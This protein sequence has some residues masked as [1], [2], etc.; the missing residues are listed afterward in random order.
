MEENEKK[1]TEETMSPQEA[2]QQNVESPETEESEALVSEKAEES[3]KDPV[4]A[5]E[6]AQVAATEST[7]VEDTVKESEPTVEPTKQEVKQLLMEKLDFEKATKEELFDAL[8]EVASNDEIRQ[9]D[10]AIKELKPV[11]EKLYQQEKSDALAAFMEQEGNEEG[12][13]KFLGDEIDRQFFYLSDNLRTKRKKY[14]ASLEKEKDANLQLKNDLLD[15]LREIVDGEETTNSINKVK[16]FQSQWKKIGPVPGQHNGALWAN[17]NALLDRFYDNRSIYFELKELDRKKNYEAKMELCEKAEALDTMTELN[18]AIK[19]LN[20]L[21]EEYKHIGPVPKEDQEALWQR[22]KGASDAVYAKRKDFYDQLKTELNANMEKKKALGE[23]LDAFATFDSDR[24]NDW[25]KKTKEL[26]ALQQEWDKIGGVPREHAKKTNKQFW[27]NFKQFFSNK[28]KFFKRLES[29]R[30]VNLDK[31]KDLIAKAEALKDSEEWDKT[32][33]ELKLLQNQW[34]EIGPVPEKFR[35]E[36]YSQ[37]RAACDHFFERKRGGG[38]PSNEQYQENLKKKK[39]ICNMLDAYLNSDVIEMDQVNGL[40]DDYADAGYV[41]KDAIDKIHSRFDKITDKLLAIEELSAEQ[42]SALELKIEVNK[43]KNSP[44]GGQKI[45]RKENTIKRDISTL[46]TEISNWR[47]NMGFFAAS[48]NATQLKLEM[49][50]KI[51]KAENELQLLKNQLK[52]L[53]QM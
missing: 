35:N 50:R 34:R 19:M 43:L 46:E 51:E 28:N 5:D 45:Q 8:K 41:P 52:V 14:Y 6:P 2:V 38:D 22:F 1:V 33:N 13:F 48:K 30:S 20:D 49:E 16:E 3:A 7:K 27:S 12:D 36:L 23:Q 9:I 44:H 4:Q 29:Q 10:R 42:R 26:L 17:F 24:I 11:Y 40:L 25:N 37:F 47:T 18:E 53:R 32:A 39:E 15:Q 21:H 31:K